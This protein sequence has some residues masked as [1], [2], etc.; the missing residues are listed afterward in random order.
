SRIPTDVYGEKLYP[1]AP[2]AYQAA[3]NDARSETPQPAQSL[4]VERVRA[5]QP[6]FELSPDNYRQ[7]TTICRELDGLPLAIELV[8]RQL[9]YRTLSEIDQQIEQR[10]DLLRQ[11]PVDWQPHHHTFRAAIQ[12]SVALLSAEEKQ[13]FARLALFAGS[14]SASAAQ[15]LTAPAII[16]RLLDAS[17]IQLGKDDRYFLLNTVR[18][19]AL[20]MLAESEAMDVAAAAH[21]HYYRNL[22]ATV[23]PH[24]ITAALTH[25]Q[26]QLA[27]E[28]DNLELAL[29]WFDAHAP[30]AGL[31]LAADLWRLW[32]IWGNYRT[33]IEWL[34]RF[35]LVES[36]PNQARC[37]ALCGLGI[38]LARIAQFEQAIPYLQS[39]LAMAHTLDDSYRSGA[40]LMGL[41]D[42]VNALGRLDEALDFYENAYELFTAANDSRT[43]S[44]ALGGIADI[45]HQRDHDVHKANELMA[46]SIRLARA[47]GEP[48]HL[49]WMLSIGA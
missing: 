2:L 48:R 26:K 36:P 14:F 18:D 46:E 34:Q 3:E 13:H 28:Q 20:E 24:L 32:Y 1:L 47:A 41:G 43:I 15:A 39:S 29:A 22:A 35:L 33:G 38:L 25:W 31:D 7:I 19:F 49:A 30:A 37:R 11:G 10:L 40:A 8:A 17:L 4:F 16:E 27:P 42:C 5:V 21:A 23:R 9:R 44:W 45:V 12:W 6:T